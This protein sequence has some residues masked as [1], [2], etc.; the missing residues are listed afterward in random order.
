MEFTSIFNIGYS[1]FRACPPKHARR[2]VQYSLQ[3]HHLFKLHRLPP[4][5]LY[6]LSS[7]QFEQQSAIE[8][9]FNFIDEPQ[10]HDMLAVGPEKS[11]FVQTFF[12]SV[13]RF[14]N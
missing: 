4:A 12:Q 11:F 5:H 3:A 10:V 8:L 6:L 7:F 2:R 13:Q 14:Q 9:R 1:I